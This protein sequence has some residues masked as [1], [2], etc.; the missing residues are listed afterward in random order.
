MRSSEKK[1]GASGVWETPWDPGSCF[2]ESRD[3]V[4]ALNHQW[5][6]CGLF[7]FCPANPVPG[8]QKTLCGVHFR[9]QLAEIQIPKSACEEEQSTSEEASETTRK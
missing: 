5:V 8:L 2:R 6:N 9:R 7:C 3:L 4:Q 1:L